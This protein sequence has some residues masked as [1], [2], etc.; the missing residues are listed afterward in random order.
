MKTTRKT[1]SPAQ[2]RD[3]LAREFRATAGDLCLKCAIPT[4]VF[5]E[6][7]SPG[8]ANWRVASGAECSNLCHTILEDLAARLSQSYDIK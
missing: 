3:L 6:P 8:R 7:A 2:L 4:P 5:I 1:V